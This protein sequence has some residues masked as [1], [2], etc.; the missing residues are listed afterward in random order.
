M[1]NNSNRGGAAMPQPNKAKVVVP[2]IDVAAAVKAAV[3]AIKNPPP[4][5][6]PDGPVQVVALAMG[7]YGNVRRNEGDKFTIASRKDLGKWMKPI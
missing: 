3:H 7:F 2:K 4:K 6:I 5:A 1:E